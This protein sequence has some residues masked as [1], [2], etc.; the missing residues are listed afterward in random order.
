MANEELREWRKKAHRVFDGD[1]RKKLD[2]KYEP[3]ILQRIV[4][5]GKFVQ[6]EH[7][8]WLEDK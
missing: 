2:E 8:E 5:L 6:A 4:E 1:E 3:L 7:P